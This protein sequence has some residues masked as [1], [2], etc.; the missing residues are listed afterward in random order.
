MKVFV[1]GKGEVVLTKNEFLAS[2][3]EGEIYRKG[4]TV[5]KIYIDPKR[6][7]PYAKIQELEEI[8][9][10]NIITPKDLII[11]DKNVPIGYTM[12]YLTDTYALCQLFPKAF[13]DRNNITPQMTLDL[14]TKMQKTIDIIHNKGIL[15]VDVNEMNFLLDNKFE[16]V[17]FIDVDSYQTKSFPATA[18]MDCIRD[19]HNTKFS[20]LTD[21]FSFG[22]LSFQMFIGIHPYKGKH[23]TL[24]TLDERMIAN[25][26]VFNKEVGIPKVC[27]PFNV[28]PQSYRDWY[29]AV[30]AEGKR[31]PPPSSIQTVIVIPVIVHTIQSN[32]SFDITELFTY[33]EEIDNYISLE[34]VR[35]TVTTKG[36]IYLDNKKKREG[37]LPFIGISPKYHRVFCAGIK[38]P[39]KLQIVEVETN[40]EMDCNIFVEKI[41]SYQ[42][43]LY[44]KNN[45]KL[46]EIDFIETPTK[47]IISSTI[48]TNVMENATRLCDGVV[49]QN[50]LGSCVC[51]I[52]PEAK[53]CY[54][55][56]IPEMK[57]YKVVDAKYDNHILV[58]IGNHNGK[59]DKFIFKINE[60]FNK[61]ELRKVEDVSYTGI[62]F[63]VLDNGIVV[64]ITEEEKMEIFSN[65]F[66]RNDVKVIDNNVSGDMIL[67]KNGTKVLFTKDKKMF[68]IKIR[69]QK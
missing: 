65:K 4:R 11:N 21:W 50:I 1:K 23:P 38:D 20:T 24:K 47:T 66:Q 26:P 8:Q 49:M 7:I 32:D 63:V 12:K 14:V 40:K 53:K 16:E 64:H 36:T 30:L 17:F 39:N 22:I 3:G 2:G 61:Y 52:F 58:I 35:A 55:I 34:T 13:K 51:S 56:I 5:Y 28:I 62:N 19:R 45:D 69:S 43:R 54:Q 44:I 10:D 18:I 37:S 6:V 67:F 31:V 60:D 9:E 41:M 59:Y 57:G 15:I 29:K 27:L 68:G 46:L 42:G 33:D 25:V 48:V